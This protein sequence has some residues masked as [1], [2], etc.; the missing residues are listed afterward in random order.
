MADTQ[1]FNPGMSLA[2]AVDLES[3]KHQVKADPGQQGGAPKAGGYVVDTSENTFQAMVQTSSTFPILLLLWTPG[4]DRLI[5]LARKLGDAVNALKGK[6]QLSRIDATAN[7]SIAQALQVQGLPALFGLI[8]GRPM[9][10]LQGLPHDDELQQVIDQIIPQLI[11]LAQQSGA[12]GTAPYT[13]ASGD[14]GGS[15]SADDV[16]GGDGDGG[17]AQQVPPE[18]MQ[19]HLLAQNGDYEGAAAAYERILEANP[20]DGLAAR[21]HAKAVLLARAGESNVREVRAQAAANPD[22]VEAQLAVADVDMIGGQIDDA[23]G[24]L[25]DYLAAGHRDQIEPVRHRLLEYFA[26]PEANDPRLSRARR[27]LATLMY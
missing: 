1:Q 27:R 21:E 13:E 4:D 22:D 25:L 23:F 9:P 26:I 20:A 19:A 2:G 11:Q 3:L 10:I 5:D 12:T 17:K 14:D 18:H 7:P 6:I 8:G 15:D 16:A 24:R